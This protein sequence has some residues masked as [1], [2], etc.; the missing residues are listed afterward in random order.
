MDGL[1]TQPLINSLQQNKYYYPFHFQAFVQIALVVIGTPVLLFLDGKFISQYL[2][3][4]QD[5]C[6]VIMAIFYLWLLF[7]AK[8]RLYWLML[9][10]TFVSFFAEVIGSIL[11]NL[12]D[13][14]LY[15]IPMYI[16]LGHAVMYAI[17][18]LICRQPLLWSHHKIIERFISRFAWGLTLLSFFILQDVAGFLCFMLF[19]VILIYRKKKLFYLA[20]FLLVYYIELLGTSFYCWSWYGTLGK[21]PAYPPIA[22]APSGIAGLYVLIDIVTNNVYYY[23]RRFM[24][25]IQRLTFTTGRSDQRVV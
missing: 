18:Y 14:R 7:T 8:G 25:W 20:M 10:M 9:L 5:Y 22:F 24:H 11:L 21:H 3:N 23:V 16:P 13:Y 19:W 1:S 15:N 6:T 2:S 17:I 12:Y 4:G